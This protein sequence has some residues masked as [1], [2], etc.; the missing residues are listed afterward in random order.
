[1]NSRNLTLC[2]FTGKYA[3]EVYKE[4]YVRKTKNIISRQNLRKK[5]IK[6]VYVLVDCI[7]ILKMLPK[8]QDRTPVN[9]LYLLMLIHAN[10]ELL[11][12]MKK[13]KIYRLV[14][15]ENTGCKNTVNPLRACVASRW[16]IVQRQLETQSWRFYDQAAITEHCCKRVIS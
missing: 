10:Y 4:N 16:K 6:D 3:S 9:S 2:L 13:I 14:W 5:F 8:I 15:H 7:T 12:A 11:L 1:M